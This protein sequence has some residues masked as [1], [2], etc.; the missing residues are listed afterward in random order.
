MRLPGRGDRNMHCFGGGFQGEPKIKKKH[1]RTKSRGIVYILFIMTDD[2]VEIFWA[3]IVHI[4]G[5]FFLFFR[6]CEVR[7]VL[8]QLFIYLLWIA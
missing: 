6:G 4:R 5:V 8:I 1:L 3:I 2:A 7:R